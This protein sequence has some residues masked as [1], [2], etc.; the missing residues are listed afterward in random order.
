MREPDARQVSQV[1]FDYAGR[2]GRE[3]DREALIAIIANMGRDLVGA[4]RCTIWLI[5]ERGQHLVARFAHGGVVPIAIDEGLVGQCVA[6]GDVILSN[7]PADDPRFAATVDRQTGYRTTSI[8]TVPMRTA[9]GR[10][11]G[12]FQAVNKP[13]GFSQAD[14]DLLGLAAAYS[15]R[16]LETQT[17]LRRAEAARR[18]ERELQIATDVQ[19]RLL[20]GSHGHAIDGV[21]FVAACRPALEV[22]GD[23]YDLLPLPDGRLSLAVGDISGKGIAAALM[24]ASVQATL[25]AL[26]LQNAWPPA[27]LVAKLNASVVDA[28]TGRYST[29]FFAL[30]DT[31]T[32]TLTAVNAG[33][34]YPLI[35]RDGEV[36]EIS[37]GGPPIGL[38]PGAV[39]AQQELTLTPGDTLL[40]YSDGLSEAQNPNGDFFGDAGLREAIV[41]AHGAPSSEVVGRIMSAADRFADGAPQAD[42]MTVVGLRIAR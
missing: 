3:Q 15:A 11:M 20:A 4:D 16:T 5:D 33:H 12:A 21:E 42:D 14:A 1:I 2:L 38:L 7:S 18:V 24:M 8:L 6:T 41:A 29:I 34:C 40:C 17:L 37:A 30:Y 35:V 22:G 10:I 27:D 19:Q 9:E 31:R 13:E 26:V 39:Y 32:R 36:L 28:S 25:H 23:Y